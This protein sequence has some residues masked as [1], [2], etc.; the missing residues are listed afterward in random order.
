LVSDFDLALDASDN[1]DFL[2]DMVE[3]H[4][5]FEQAYAP[6]PIRLYHIPDSKLKWIG[7]A[8]NCSYDDA[9]SELMGI[10]RL[11]SL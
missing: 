4:D 3:E 11:N 1:V 8:N 2:V 7:Q 9:V 10:L 5:P 6:W